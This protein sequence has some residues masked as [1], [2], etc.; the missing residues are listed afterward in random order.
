[1]LACLS[2]Y[3]SASYD[4]SPWCSDSFCVYSRAVGS[5]TPAGSRCSGVLMTVCFQMVIKVAPLCPG[6][7]LVEAQHN[8]AQLAADQLALPT[9]PRV[10]VLLPLLTSSFIL[11][12]F[13]FHYPS[14]HHRHHC[15]FAPS[16]P[17]VSASQDNKVSVCKYAGL[18]LHTE[19]DAAIV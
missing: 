18:P 15:C 10:R 13:I 14:C 6:L 1:M 8:R 12:F 19:S 16:S 3:L 5:A 9:Y 11:F 17:A 2:V 4:L 7:F